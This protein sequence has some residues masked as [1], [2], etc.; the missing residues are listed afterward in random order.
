MVNLSK[1]ARLAGLALLVPL[2]GLGLSIPSAAGEG[3][4]PVQVPTPAV[5]EP[6]TAA[7]E[8]AVFAGGCFWGVQGVFQH[9]KGVQSAIAGYSGGTV[10]NPTYV[11]VGGEQ[12]GLA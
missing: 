4:L 11:M 5:D 10:A 9:V 1:I 12:T 7:T 2:V 3:L 6:A 8:T